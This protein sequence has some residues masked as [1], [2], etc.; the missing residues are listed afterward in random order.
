MSGRRAAADIFSTLTG[1]YS[2]PS[3]VGLVRFTPEK[4]D[5]LDWQHVWLAGLVITFPF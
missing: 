3:L 2:L 4:C 5:R 1:L